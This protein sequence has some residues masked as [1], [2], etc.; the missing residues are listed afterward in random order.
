[1]SFGYTEM[2]ADSPVIDIQVTEK[3]CWEGWEEI[4][5]KINLFS[6]AIKK[7][8]TIICLECYPGTYESVNLNALKSGLN[9]SAIC[10]TNDLFKDEKEIK[11]MV[12]K[13]IP[14]NGIF[15]KVASLSIEDFFQNKKKQSILN[16]IG[17]I[18]SGTILIY[19]V[20][21]SHIF[22]P[23]I[24]I[25]ADMSL[26]EIQQRFRRKDIANIGLH[27]QEEA[28]SKHFARGFFIDW[29]I[30]NNI[31]KEVLKKADYILDTNNWQKPKMVEGSVLREGL[32]VAAQTPFIQ[33]PF[34]NPQFWDE[35]EQKNQE[36]DFYWYYSC[37][38]EEN[39]LLF[40]FGNVLFESP[41][42]NVIYL[43]PKKVL[44]KTVYHIFGAEL[45]LRMKFV[46]SVDESDNEVLLQVDP[47]TEQKKTIFGFDCKGEESYYVL[48]AEEGASM[49]FGLKKGTNKADILRV[50][51]KKKPEF[52]KV[53]N[54]IP[55]K[56]H[57]HFTVPAGMPYCTGFKSILLKVGIFT[58][59][60]N[61]KLWQKNS[62]VVS[63]QEQM[64]H[65]GL[66][67]DT[68][69]FDE[70]IYDAENYVNKSS[71]VAEGE[72]W[73]EEQLGC[74]EHQLIRIVKHTFTAPVSHKTK[75]NIQV[76]NLVKGSKVKVE[77]TTGAFQPFLVYYSQT[78]IVP[79]SVDEFRILP[80]NQE[81][82]EEFI[83]LKVFIRN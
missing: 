12:D 54:K 31:K 26:Y 59:F 7:E 78:F 37:V 62:N 3:C 8:K 30:G 9:P 61:F 18:D 63:M 71:K 1:M 64:L 5:E 74:V 35:P 75:G 11:E 42:V 6:S 46:D 77:S 81:N 65:R 44:G 55:V 14:E 32:S 36:E 50:I 56:E 52:A 25:Y 39:S 79:A 21:A 66:A 41:V 10:L 16:N 13:Y 29:Q 17:Q 60:L 57:Q 45:P 38:P 24:L 33:A 2:N 28:Y 4:V 58:D 40:R 69:A 53:F 48:A 19:G 67:L 70:D 72:G 73:I 47:D 83:T 68:I 27:N 22:E 80:L 23:D 76:I 43:Y 20:G 15:G 34:F 51:D 82:D 49:L